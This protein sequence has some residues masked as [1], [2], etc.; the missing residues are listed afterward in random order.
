M[1]VRLKEWLELVDKEY[2]RD[3]IVNGGA[4][5]KF[6]VA[7]DANIGATT[8]GLASQAAKQGLIFTDINSATAKLHMIQ[9]V[10]FAISRKIAWEADAQRFVEELFQRQGYQ[11]PSPGEPV[12]LG[13]I[14]ESHKVDATILR[15]EFYRWLT[16]HLMNDMSMAQDFR[17]AVMQLCLNRLA[18]AADETGGTAPILEWLR[19]ELRVLSPLKS[20]NIF[21]KITRHNARAMLRSLCRWLALAGHK[22]LLLVIDIRQLTRTASAVT[23]GIRYTSAAV[24]D[25][26]EVLRQL[27]DDVDLFERFFIAVFADHA[28]IADDPKRSAST[29]TALKLRIWDDVRARAQDNPLAPMVVIEPSRDA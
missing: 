8:E 16:T 19:G 25:A 20:A 12:A 2:L 17:I 26:Y 24:M 9:D 27:V 6:L 10:F 3:F 11:W 13:E 14:A 28:F 1:A 21:S 29:Y 22:G 4:A 5:V 15:R 7:D 18:P 23:D